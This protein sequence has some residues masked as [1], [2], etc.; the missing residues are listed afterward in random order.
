MTTNIKYIQNIVNIHQENKHNIK[1]DLL[2]IFA[3]FSIFI[4]IFVIIIPVLLF[5]NKLYSILEAYM[6]NLDLIATIITWHGGPF[7][8]WEHLYPSSPLTI[9][10]F[11]SQTI[12]NYMALL[13]LTYIISR[14]TKRTNSLIKG[15][16]LAFV[17]LLMTYL[18][19]SQFISWCMNESVNFLQYKNLP[20]AD[21]TIPFIIG[22]IVTTCIISL[23]AYIIKHYRENVA[24]FAEKLIKLP[25]LLKK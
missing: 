7:Q 22:S 11:A 4:L 3:G 18:L 23:E 12:I 10:G 6:P 2:K 16:S 9:Y 19:P 20:I 5:K 25:K 1:T 21:K 24:S 17:M 8:I 15:W 14:E 13:G